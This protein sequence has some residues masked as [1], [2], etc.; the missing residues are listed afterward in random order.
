[1]TLEKLQADMI[2]AL[3]NKDTF[4]K[5]QLSSL[6]AAV[7]KAGIDNFCRDKIP[8]EIVNKALLKEQKMAQEMLNTCPSER[9][10]EYAKIKKG[11]EIINEYAPTLLSDPIEIKNQ[12][13]Q[14]CDNADVIISKKN[15]SAAMKIIMPYFKGKA[16][17]KIVSKIVSELFSREE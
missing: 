10:D 3:K 4:R 12:I 16:D 2:A 15:K 14:L 1:M 7:K 17:M 5:T 8:E 11:L 13:I 6:V 9:K